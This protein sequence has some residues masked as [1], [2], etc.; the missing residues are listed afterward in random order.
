MA[1]C[2]VVLPD[3]VR[4]PLTDGDFLIVKK[5]LNAGEY[6]D[7]LTDSATGKAFPAVVAYLVGWTLVGVNDAPIADGLSG[8]SLRASAARSVASASTGSGSTAVFGV[9]VVVMLRP[10][11]PFLLQRDAR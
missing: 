7:S 1:R 5:E 8:R 3:T 4:L 2:R 11:W 9:A 10:R 6:I